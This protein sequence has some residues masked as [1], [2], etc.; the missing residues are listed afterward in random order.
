M[1]TYTSKEL[2][3]HEALILFGGGTYQI[4]SYF[5]SALCDKK[6]GG[7]KTFVRGI[8]VLQNIHGN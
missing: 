7:E 5:F 3:F 2:Y 1:V 4:S 6:E 8:G